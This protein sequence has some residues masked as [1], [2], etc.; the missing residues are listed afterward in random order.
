M[1]ALSTASN[2]FVLALLAAAPVPSG[3]DGGASEE[4][5]ERTGRP[6]RKEAGPSC[7]SV[8]GREACGYDCKIAH[9]AEVKCAATPQGRCFEG[10]GQLICFDPPQVAV[11]VLRAPFP[12]P[13]C[14]AYAEQVACGYHCVAEAGAL[15]CAATPLGVCAAAYGQARCFDPPAEVL[16]L[17]GAST[18]QAE[19]HSES[20]QIACGYHCV[21]ASGIL[22]C[23]TTP[24][25]VCGHEGGIAVCFDPPT[26]VQCAGGKKLVRPSCL[27]A[28]GQIACGYA[29]VEVHGHL[30]CA[31]TPQG[32]CSTEGELPVCFDPP[33]RGGQSAESDVCFGLLGEAG[34]AVGIER[35]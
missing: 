19:C 6:A 29:C 9:A 17:Y 23:A 18:P 28:Q 26:G 31:N 5:P 8:L 14:R 27:H 1:L 30:R 16:S 2:L 24:A 15:A 25:G 34:A 11:R 13:E 7:L 3:P 33:V 21:V 20:G 10:S 12:P 4:A 32:K 35:R 22:R